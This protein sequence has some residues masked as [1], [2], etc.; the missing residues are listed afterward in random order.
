M[1]RLCS[2]WDFH[3]VYT[4][5][6]Y[7]HAH[8]LTTVC[9]C[10]SHIS[11]QT[12]A[13]KWARMSILK[14]ALFSVFWFPHVVLCLSIIGEKKFWQSMLR[15]RSLEPTL[16]DGT[17]HSYMFRPKKL[18]LMQKKN[19]YCYHQMVADKT[20]ISSVQCQC[21]ANFNLSLSSSCESFI[22]LIQ[23]GNEQTRTIV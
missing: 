1:W 16:A 17:V 2:S 5:Y 22:L 11:S 20:M 8:K 13:F 4:Y 14:S 18:F 10:A 9:H 21:V 19:G 7:P 23:F 3:A 15:T 6:R 12:K